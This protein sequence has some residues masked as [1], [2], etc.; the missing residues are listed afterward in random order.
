MRGEKDKNTNYKEG[1]EGETGSDQVRKGT[2]HKK[3]EPG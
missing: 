2:A 1:N 3:L